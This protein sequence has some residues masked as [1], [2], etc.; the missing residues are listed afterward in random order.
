[1]PRDRRL[2]S[3]RARFTTILL[4]AALALPVA[5][6]WAGKGQVEPDTTL[7]RQGGQMWPDADVTPGAR[8]SRVYFN[9][10]TVQNGGYGAHG[11]TTNPN[12][13]TLETQR[14][15]WPGQVAAMLGVWKDCNR[16]GYV[17]W[18][19]NGLF[20]YRVELLR[21]DASVC[22][23]VDPGPVPSGAASHDYVTT[24][25]DGQWV[26]ELIPLGPDVRPAHLPDVNPYD[27]NDNDARVWADWGRPG[28]APP[29]TRCHVVFVPA[30]TYSTTGGMLAYVDCLDDHLVTDLWNALVAGAGGDDLGLGQLSFKDAPRDQGSSD[31]TLNRPN[32]WG[33]PGDASHAEAFDCAQPQVARAKVPGT[34]HEVGASRPST[35]PAVRPDGSVAGTLNATATALDDCDRGDN[36]GEWEHQP[37]ALPYGLEDPGIRNSAGPRD[38]SDFPMS[39]SEGQRPAG[40]LTPAQLGRSTP[41]DQGTRAYDSE[42]M[43]LSGTRVVEDRNPYASRASAREGAFAP[44]QYVTAY[45]YVGPAAVSKYGLVLNPTGQS[46]AYGSEA[47]GGVTGAG[48]PPR[49]GWRCDPAEW[50]RAC[51]QA[52]TCLGSIAGRADVDISVQVGHPYQL[53]DVDCYDGSAGVLREQ[54]VSWGLL[55][56][57]RCE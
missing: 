12:L 29:A 1:M 2:D 45:A 28:D 20:E 46:G 40:L 26:H 38:A 34:A 10:F 42:G 23:A 56:G 36:R 8:G 52:Y 50:S 48:A 31:S 4:A 51:A 25:N 54:G 16:D 57:T 7:D 30:G 43:W 3:L 33:R 32:P 47:C 44:V 11:L 13:A 6:A 22:P 15:G 55:S 18:G 17:G 19:D 49:G 53:R 21:G 27:L 14:Q 24:H 5:A 35:S 37:S 39:Y 41:K 9:A